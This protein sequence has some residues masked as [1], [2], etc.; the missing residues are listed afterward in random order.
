MARI[1]GKVLTATKLYF[2]TAYN[3]PTSLSASVVSDAVYGAGWNGVTT[4]APSKNAVY[5]KI[6][7]LASHTQNTDTGTTENTF[8]IDSDSITGKI[9]VDVALGAADKSLTITNT[10][11]TDD[12]VITFPDV[13]GTVV[14]GG[15]T[16]SGSNTGDETAARIATIITGAGAEIPLDADEFPFY[17]IV[18]TLLKKVTWANIKA[19]LKTYFDTIYQA[20]GSYLTSANI[21]DTAYDAT[22]WNAVTTIAP[23]KNAVRDKIES[24]DGEKSDVGHNHIIAIKQLEAD[25]TILADDTWEEI[26]TT[27]IPAGITS[28]WVQIIA[29]VTAQDTVFADRPFDVRILRGGSQILGIGTVMLMDGD[30]ETLTVLGFVED[31]STDDVISV[32]VRRKA[33]DIILYNYDSGISTQMVISQ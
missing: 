31:G 4:I 20:A 17:K 23:S 10:A 27:T 15:G 5:D 24:L 18:G 9:I 12:R 28:S 6:E 30:Y 11:L 1:I 22:S 7:T 8:T 25:Y 26:L 33:G 3:A 16:A 32:E 2:D 29:M 19:T 14:T 21:S 13:T